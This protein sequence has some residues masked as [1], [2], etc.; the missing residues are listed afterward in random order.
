MGVNIYSVSPLTGSIGVQLHESIEVI[1]DTS[2]DMTT[3]GI[4][5]LFIEGSDKEIASGPYVPL[6][7]QGTSDVK[8][9]IDPAYHGIVQATYS[10]EYLSTD[11]TTPLSSLE[12]TSGTDAYFTKVIIQPIRPLTPLHPYKIYISGT[13]TDGDTIGIASRTVFDPIPDPGN[14]GN[15]SIVPHGGYRGTAEGTFTVNILTGGVV[16]DATYRWKFNSGSFNPVSLSHTHRRTFENGVALSFSPEGTFQSGDEFKF[17]VKPKTYLDSISVSNFTTGEYGTQVLPVDT[18]SI[19]SRVAPP[20]S[21]AVTQPGFSL[22]HTV[23]ENISCGI[24]PLT[25]KFDFLL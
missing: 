11:G 24:D 16:G 2:I 22:H 1:F 7:F 21:G 13:S 15:A 19:V 6:N 5:S 9:M 3:V 4:G 8:G 17:L 18:A 12:D 25:Q 20:F 10:Y 23:P 14:S